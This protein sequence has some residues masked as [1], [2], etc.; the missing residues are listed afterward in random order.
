MRHFWGRP[1]RAGRAIRPLR[2][3]SGAFP[4]D[5]LVP[6]RE[7]RC[8]VVL[9]RRLGWTRDPL[10]V[11]EGAL[12]GEQPALVIVRCEIH[13]L[14]LAPWKGM[15]DSRSLQ[16]ARR[17]RLAKSRSGATHAGPYALLCSSYFGAPRRSFMKS[18]NARTF[19]EVTSPHLA[20]PV[21]VVAAKDIPHSPNANR[22]QNLSV[23]LP[24]TSETSKLIGTPADSLPNRDSQSILPRYHVHIHGGAWR[25]TQLTS[26]SIEP[27]VAHLRDDYEMFLSNAFG[28]DKGKWPAAECITTDGVEPSSCPRPFVVLRRT[29]TLLHEIDECAHVRG[30]PALAREHNVYVDRWD[31]PVGE[32][33]HELARS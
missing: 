8:R 15:F 5:V 28:A 11:D 1:A 9:R 25:D 32:E 3:P 13:W 4:R 14:L 23:Y 10:Q 19:G 30:Q 31:R 12:D 16:A 33:R 21:S 17:L 29:E 7:R 22:F 20:H 18:T 27:A 6:P 2:S 26:K 24:K